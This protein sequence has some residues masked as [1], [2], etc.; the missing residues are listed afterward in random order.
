MMEQASDSDDWTGPTTV[1]AGLHALCPSSSARRGAPTNSF[2]GVAS[3]ETN[4]PPVGGQ[5]SLSAPPLWEPAQRGT[6]EDLSR[7]GFLKYAGAALAGTVLSGHAARVLA[8]S[9]GSER[10]NFIIIFCDDL[11]YGGV[12]CF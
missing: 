7:R 12:G 3:G 1:Q 5:T 8:R 4:P 11:G 6:C 10:P 9:D 2:V